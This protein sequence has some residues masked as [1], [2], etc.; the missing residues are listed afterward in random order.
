MS[1][2]KLKICNYE[3]T[4]NI[5]EETA[6]HYFVELEVYPNSK[7]P[8]EKQWISKDKIEYIK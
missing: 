3:H 7:Y 5:L 8:F 2:I 1:T 6:L 4:G